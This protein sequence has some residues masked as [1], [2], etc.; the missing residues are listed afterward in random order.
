MHMLVSGRDG[1][2]P[3]WA[4]PEMPTDRAGVVTSTGERVNESA[5]DA[6]AFVEN[7]IDSNKPNWQWT[8]DHVCSDDLLVGLTKLAKSLLLALAANTGSTV[9]EVVAAQRDVFLS[10]RAT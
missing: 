2:R 1:V 6:L 9:G 7:I 10:E 5:L 8:L 3:G 4:V